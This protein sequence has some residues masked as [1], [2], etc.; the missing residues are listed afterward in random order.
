MIIQS[1]IKLISTIGML[2]IGLFQSINA[3]GL[4]PELTK[5][6]EQQRFARIVFYNCENLFDTINDSLKNDEE[7]LP[8]GDRFWTP[9]KYKNKLNNISRVITAI[10]GWSPP[11]IIGLCEIENA[12]TIHDLTL[13]TQLYRFEY[14]FIHNES[15]DNRGIDVAL[16]YQP[17]AYLPIKN[18]FISINFPTQPKKKT[19][20]ILYSK[21]FLNNSDTLHLFV[22]HWPSR[23][24][25]ELESEEYRTFVASVLKHKTD[26]I[27]RKNAVANILIMGDFNDEPTNISLSQVLSAKLEIQELM[28]ST[29]YNLTYIITKSSQAGTHKYQGNWTILDQFIVSG[30]LLNQKSSINTKPENLTI[31]NANFLMEP[32]NTYLG[33]KPYRTFT[34]FKYNGGFSDHLP[35]FIDLNKN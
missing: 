17:E 31:F 3:Q 11:E 4:R 10:G 33:N 9:K 23:W 7:F 2:L 20:Q 26:S 6:V 35:I 19:R 28:D 18:T 15:P 21:G 14:K 13:N 8:E 5:K 16:L 27:F 32:D 1:K 30:N 25:G 12:K 24:G 22:N 29:L 34:G